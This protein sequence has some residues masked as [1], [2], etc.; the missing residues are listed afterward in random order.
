MKSF[1]RNLILAALC[2][3]LAA[4]ATGRNRVPEAPIKAPTPPPVA[5]GKVTMVNQELGFVLIQSPVSPETGA[6]LQSRDKDG[7]ETASLRVSGEKKPPF[8]IADILKG[9]PH[10]GD[11]VTK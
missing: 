6:A 11:T 1:P 4:C 9:K 2:L 10:A 5:V 3:N 7:G 8:I